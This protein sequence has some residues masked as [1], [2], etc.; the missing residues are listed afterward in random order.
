[1]NPYQ[2]FPHVVPTSPLRA[3]QEA[4]GGPGLWASV[5]ILRLLSAAEALG[6]SLRPGGARR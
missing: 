5:L 6:R 3:G 1:M 4:P 2:A